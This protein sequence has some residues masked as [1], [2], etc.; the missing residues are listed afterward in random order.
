MSRIRLFRA[1]EPD[2]FSTVYAIPEFT[3]QN[4]ATGL[5]PGLHEWTKDLPHQV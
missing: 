1:A 5:V 3:K 4:A 2:V